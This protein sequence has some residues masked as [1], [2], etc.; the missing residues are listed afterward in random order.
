MGFKPICKSKASD[1][2]PNGPKIHPILRWSNSLASLFKLDH[3]QITFPQLGSNP[4]Q[5]YFF[6]APSK[7]VTHQV[8]SYVGNLNLIRASHERYLATHHDPQLTR[9]VNGLTANSLICNILC[10]VFLSLHTIPYL[11]QSM[12][13]PQLIGRVNGL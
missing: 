7:C 2:H 10:N 8:Y 1:T 6:F 12:H 13:D 9:R 4:S 3:I 11:V 5:F